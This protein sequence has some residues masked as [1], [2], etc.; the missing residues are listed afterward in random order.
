MINLDLLQLAQHKIRQSKQAF[1]PPMGPMDPTAAGGAPPAAAGPPPGA[2]PAGLPGGA[3]PPP[4]MGPMDP[5]AAAGGQMPPGFAPPPPQAA[6]QGP[7]AGAKPKFDP[8]A[9]DYRMYN[10]QQQLTAIM[11]ALQI[12]LPPGSLVM[13]PGTMGAPPAEQAAPGAPMD[14]MMQPGAQPAGGQPQQSSIPPID[15][16]QGAAPQ[17][18]GAAPAGGAPKTAALF[19]NPAGQL[20]FPDA[21][22]TVGTP[23][24]RP[25]GLQLSD[26]AA[27]LASVWRSRRMAAMGQT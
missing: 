24:D 17:Q 20:D 1:T 18:P 4:P 25:P 5:V 26:K 3:P 10:V 13:P 27:A 7:A 11:N 16:I 8:L 2:P 12:Q 6:P 9:L 19:E 14:P 23:C 15:A 21:P 22:S